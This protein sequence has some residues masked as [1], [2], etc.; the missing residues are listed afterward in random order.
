MTGLAITAVRHR[1]VF[2]LF[3]LLV[4][5]VVMH[6]GCP[7][8][9]TITVTDMAKRTVNVPQSPER[10]ICAAPRTLRLICYLGAQDKVAGVEQFEKR[11]LI[12]RPYWLAN[13]WLAK[14]PSIGPGGPRPSIVTQTS[15]RFS[16][17]NL[18]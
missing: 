5:T 4:L 10:I 3:A 6:S 1:T 11:M 15:K 14:L 18:T 9:D 2:L 13:P 8:T 7:A 17:S 16:R 12:S